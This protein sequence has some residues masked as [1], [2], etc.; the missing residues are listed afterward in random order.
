METVQKDASGE[1]GWALSLMGGH[2]QGKSWL[3]HLPRTAL[4]CATP[5]QRAAPLLPCA[6]AT[7]PC[8][9]PGLVTCA[10]EEVRVVVD[11]DD[12]FR[13]DCSPESLAKLRP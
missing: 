12:S 4:R 11:A 13:A 6:C 5:R 3:G 7:R 9:A 1:A 8:P 10:G 2:W